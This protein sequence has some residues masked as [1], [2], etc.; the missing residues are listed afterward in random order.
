MMRL[1]CI[2]S[3]RTSKSSNNCEESSPCVC[4]RPASPPLGLLAAQL[5]YT[6]VLRTVTFDQGGSQSGRS[7]HGA[8][9]LQG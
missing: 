1:S 9:G 8:A 6:L 5:A 3:A 7:V 2:C 4:S